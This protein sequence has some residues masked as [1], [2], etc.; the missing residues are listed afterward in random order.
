MKRIPI[1]VV[2]A[3]LSLGASGAE[4]TWGTPAELQGGDGLLDM[5]GLGTLVVALNVNGGDVSVGGV[6]F[7]ET[8]ASVISLTGKGYV[9]FQCKN[10]VPAT[11]AA[12]SDLLNTGRYLVSRITFSDLTP[13]NKYLVQIWS[14]DS[15]DFTSGRNT[16]FLTGEESVTLKQGETTHLGECVV[17]TF[18][19]DG[20]TQ[21][22]LVSST[23]GADNAVVNA[24]QLR[25]I[26]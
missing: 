12:Y 25:R 18:T 21:T 23:S 6:E 9:G 16:I 1:L 2:M 14:S 24:I 10:S 20:P 15:R 17:G 5:S 8:A 19:A 3:A 22:I 7:R 4:V 13:G 26:P 11:D